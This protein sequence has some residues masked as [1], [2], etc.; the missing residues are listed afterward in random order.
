M[1]QKLYMM[2]GLPGSGKGTWS[3][4]NLPSAFRLS[5]D[6]Y[7]EELAKK[8]ELTYNEMFELMIGEA[9]TRLNALS[10]RISKEGDSSGIVV[11]DQ[12]NLTVSSRKHKLKLFSPDKWERIAVYV[13]AD[14]ETLLRV[15]EKRKKIGRAIPDQVIKSMFSKLEVPTTEEGFDKVLTISRNTV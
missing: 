10:Q 2:V 6:D 9:T 3:K 14:K 15:N 12:T 13:S 4:K 11:W 8:Y 7:I 5:T 1:K